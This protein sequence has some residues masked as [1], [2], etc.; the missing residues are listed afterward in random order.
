M[1][2]TVKVVATDSAVTGL[3]VA[4]AVTL[5]C[6]SLSQHCQYYCCHNAV[7]V[8]AATALCSISLSQSCAHRCLTALGFI[9][10]SA[11]H[12]EILPS[13]GEARSRAPGADTLRPWS[14]HPPR[15]SRALPGW[16]VPTTW[17][18]NKHNLNGPFWRVFI[19]Q[20]KSLK[21]FGF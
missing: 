9:L 21:T 5:M 8:F 1:H 12:F 11:E 4:I 19:N 17:N 16:T 2:I 6:T 10:C 14:C 15:A 18:S 7:L 3:S 13:S 20:F